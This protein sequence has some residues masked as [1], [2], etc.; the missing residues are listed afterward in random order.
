MPDYSL[1]GKMIHIPSGHFI[2][3]TDKKDRPPKHFPWAFLNHGMQM[4]VP[5]KKFF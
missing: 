5:K 2:F 1:E 4:K 3:G